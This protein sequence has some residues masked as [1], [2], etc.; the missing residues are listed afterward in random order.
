MKTYT[1]ES[2][3]GIF[4]S[5]R[6]MVEKINSRLQ[7]QPS[8]SEGYLE[9]VGKSATRYDIAAWTWKGRILESW[10]FQLIY[11]PDD[12][13]FS[14]GVVDLDNRESS[15]FEDYKTSITSENVT[16]ALDWL[17]SEVHLD[18]GLTSPQP[19][20]ESVIMSSH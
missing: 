3:Y 19:V 2:L 20:V 6:G 17:C 10:M 8:F 13:M 18:S 15:P 14:L 11:D 4:P 16:S 5:L 12:G 9:Y 1:E 7:T